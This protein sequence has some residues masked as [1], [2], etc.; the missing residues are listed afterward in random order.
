M[1]EPEFVITA[2][3]ERADPHDALVM[4]AGLENSYK[5]LEDLPEGSV[6]GTSSVRRVAG[7][8]RDFPGLKFMDV[9]SLGLL[10]RIHVGTAC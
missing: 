9:V 6:V 4:K 2:V 8:R 1:L 3:L 10:C 5:R 7:L